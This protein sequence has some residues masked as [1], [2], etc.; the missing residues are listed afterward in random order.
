MKIEETIVRTD[1]YVTEEG[2]PYKVVHYWNSKADSGGSWHVWGSY[3][4]H[5]YTR[6][7]DPQKPAFKRIVAAVKELLGTI[8]AAKQ[9]GRVA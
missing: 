3:G 9:M 1:Y 5:R 2:V 7:L 4:T 8:D 6:Q